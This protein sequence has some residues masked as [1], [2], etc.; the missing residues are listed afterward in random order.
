MRSSVA[1]PTSGGV[2]GRHPVGAPILEAER[3]RLELERPRPAAH[4]HW[5]RC[6]QPVRKVHCAVEALVGRP[7][8]PIVWTGVRGVGKTIARLEARRLARDRKFVTV[9]VTRSARPGWPSD[10]PSQ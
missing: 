8:A 7:G 9:D 4:R 3:V 2:L 5:R 1:G 6:R 10:W